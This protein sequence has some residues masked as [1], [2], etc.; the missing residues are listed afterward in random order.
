MDHITEQDIAHALDILD[1][2]LPITTED[3]ERAKRVQLYNWNPSRYAGLTNNPKHYMQQFQKAEDMT[4]TI[5]AAYALISAVFI[6]D[7]AER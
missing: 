3:L 6:P 4:R 5:E 1:L 2:T 7:E